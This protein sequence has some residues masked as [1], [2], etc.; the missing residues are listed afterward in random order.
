VSV[1]IDP[2]AWHAHGR[3]WSHLVSDTDLA[4]LHAFASELGIPRRAFEGD[5]YDIPEERYAAVVAAGALEVSGRELLRSLTSAGLRMQKRLGDK[6][7]AR[8]L[9]VPL[10]S[11]AVADVDLFASSRPMDERRV[12]AA[13]V[14]LRDAAGDLAVVHSDRR[15]EW[16]SPGVG[17]WG[18]NPSGQRGPRAVRRRASTCT[19]D[20]RPCGYE[21]FRPVSGTPFVP[22]G[23]VSCGPTWRRC[24]C[25]GHRSRA[26]RRHHGP[27]MGDTQ[28]YGALWPPLLVATGTTSARVN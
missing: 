15:Q 17:V 24:R 3:A 7:I 8:Q 21:R 22:S 18:L 13:M 16:G 23:R 6:G 27:A 26:T 1:L 2:P 28:Q 12:F 4:E 10:I 9:A 25:V 11:G 14:F 5:H 19:D 20:L